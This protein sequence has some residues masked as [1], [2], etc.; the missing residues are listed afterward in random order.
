MFFMGKIVKQKTNKTTK[1]G[2]ELT[3]IAERE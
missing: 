3:I 1:E 2:C